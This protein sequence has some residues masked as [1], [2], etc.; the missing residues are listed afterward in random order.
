MGLLSTDSLVASK[1]IREIIQLSASYYDSLDPA[2]S[3]DDTQ[4]FI[5]PKFLQMLVLLLS[6]LNDEDL[7]EIKD[8][9]ESTYEIK[10]DRPHLELLFMKVIP[11][12]SINSKIF[13]KSLI[14]AFEGYPLND[15]CG[16]P[17]ECWD[18][19]IQRLLQ[20]GY[21]LPGT[22]TDLGRASS[23]WIVKWPEQGFKSSLVF[24]NLQYAGCSLKAINDIP[25]IELHPEACMAEL[26][27]FLTN[28]E[29]YII[30]SED[31][32]RITCLLPGSYSVIETGQ[33]GKNFD[34]EIQEFAINGE[35]YEAIRRMNEIIR[36]WNLALTAPSK[37]RALSF[38][39][40]GQK[41]KDI[42][43]LNDIK[44]EQP[45]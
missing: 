27:V 12:M 3:K 44:G 42:G 33:N 10:A 35:L 40:R 21:I 43:F 13:I 4:K 19:F 28:G 9:L 26:T 18:Y 45:P 38:P 15:D 36:H 17:E 2:G 14:P 6:F 39:F 24:N 22:V 8:F 7:D 30:G 16:D 31:L 37:S 29:K 25:P 11:L 23:S 41:W 20:H 34:L 5:R 1:G 32:E